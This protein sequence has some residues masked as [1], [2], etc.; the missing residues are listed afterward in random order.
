MTDTSARM[1][2]AGGVRPAAPGGAG[3]RRWRMTRGRSNAGKTT[4]ALARVAELVAAGAS[5]ETVLLVVGCDAAAQDAR[6]ALAARRGACAS[7][8]VATARDL[9]LELL[10]SPRAREFTGRQARLLTRFE[11]DFVLEDAKTTGQ[12]A[13]RL[14]GMLGFF[15]K[16]LTELADDD[17]DAFL[18]DDDE[19]AAFASVRASL[20]AM[21]AIHPCE[22]AGMAVRWMRSLGEGAARETP[23]EHVVVDDYQLLNRA[24]QH[25]LELLAPSDL[26]AFG[27]DLA[28]GAGADPFPYPRGV[29][30]F[31]ERHPD[32]EKVDLPDPDAPG[33]AGAAAALAA[34]GFVAARSLG[35]ADSQ[36]ATDVVESYDVVPEATPRAGVGTLETRD[37]RGEFATVARRARGLVDAGAAP[38]DVIIAVPNR[39]WGGQVCAALGDAGLPWQRMGAGAVPGG[40]VRD[41]GRCGA[42][43]MMTALCLVADPSDQASWRAWCGYGDF[44]GRSGAFAGLERACRDEGVEL[45]QAIEE[46]P[47]RARLIERAAQDRARAAQERADELEARAQGRGGDPGDDV[48]AREL[49]RA[50]SDVGGDGAARETADAVM[51]AREDARA[52]REEAERLG[53]SLRAVHEAYEQGVR[54]RG[55]VAGLRGR[56]LVDRLARHLGLDG[57]PAPIRQAVTGAARR[58]GVPPDAVDAALI[59]AE[60]RRRTL[61]DGFEGDPEGVR[62]CPYDRLV[63]VKGAHVILSGCMDGWFPE[64]AFFDLTEASYERRQAIDARCRRD[65]YRLFGCS[66]ETLD[67]SSFSRCDLEVAERLDLREYRIAAGD[68]GGRVALCERSLIADYALDALGVRPIDLA[69]ARARLAGA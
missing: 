68:E 38:R 11:N 16:S 7:V 26:W 2:P 48:R 28:L 39:T 37:F 56:E 58:A 3:E 15:R 14:K 44:L 20:E 23:Y 49:A 21:R 22:L 34:G 63:A 65:M 6:R 45:S 18:L 33:C 27:D 69:R 50:L 57:A 30:E 53:P 31:L 19:R 61:C 43:R 40:D 52:A 10:S 59:A 66:L 32:A 4:G 67:V 8:R 36:G 9:E 64:H 47:L 24:S 12:R 13:S 60:L 1:A 54:I 35:T 46:I 42:A 55:E 41:L 51:R 5:P 62:V 17:M 29:G 25:L